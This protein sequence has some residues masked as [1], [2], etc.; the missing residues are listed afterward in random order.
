[1][2]GPDVIVAWLQHDYGR[3]GRASEAIAHALVRSGAAGRVAY[4]EPFHQEPGEPELSARND[5]GLLVYTG[6][7]A[8]PSGSHEV[9]QGVIS[10]AEMHHPVL[11]N[12]GVSETNWW[13]HYEFAPLCSRTVLVTYDKLAEW[14]AAASRRE[15]LERV[16]RQLITAS[17]VVCALSEGSVDD[18][19]EATYVGHGIDDGWLDPSVDTLPEPADLAAIPHPRAVYLGALSMRFDLE[20]V[21][22]LSDTGVEVVLIGL[23]PPA[24]LLEL[25][26][27]HAHVHFLGERPP[28]QTPAYLRHCDVGIIPHTD[29]PFTRSMEPHKA[30]NYA[31]AGLP[32]VTLNTAHAPA[33]DTFLEATTSRD[34]FVSAVQAAV[35]RGRL[36]DPQV[37]QARSLTWDRV[38]NAIL[39][40]IPA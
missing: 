13:F 20:A 34:Q 5:R 19:L 22:D 32:T 14:E 18:V 15:I 37:K 11:L 38:A 40:A 35:E 30:Y 27:D 8:P 3:L 23:A 10:L 2:A 6:R 28:T 33:L 16:R 4:V 24:A 36:S 21:R 17:D 26:R 7:G 12:F 29:E 25:A 31:A 9:A 39:G 1:M